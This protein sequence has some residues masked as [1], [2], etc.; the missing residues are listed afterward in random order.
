MNSDSQLVIRGVT[1]FEEGATID[2]AIVI[3]NSDL[4]LYAGPEIQLPVSTSRFTIIDGD[5][6]IVSP[7][8]IDLQINGAYGFDF[9]SQTDSIPSV[10]SRLPETG[11]TSFLPTLITSPIEDY[12][13]KLRA[14][15][16]AQQELVGARVLGA[17][18]E[19]PFLNKI[20][21]GAHNPILF[22]EPTTALL[23]KIFPLEVVRIV[24]LA[25][26]LFHSLEAIRWLVARGIIVSMGH[27]AANEVETLAAIGAGVTYGTHLFNAMPAMHHRTPG[28]VGVF[29]TSNLARFGL[30]VDGLH[31]HPR[32]VQMAWK[33]RGHKGITLITDAMEGMGMPHGEYKVGNRKVT[34]SE[35]GAWLKDGTSLAGSILSMDEAV[36]NMI[37]FSGCTPAQAIRMASTTPAEVLRI[38]DKFG[39][40]KSGYIA[41]ITIFDR[42]LLVQATIVQGTLVFSTPSAQERF[43]K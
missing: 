7:G 22:Y 25:P 23:E 11:V 41:D 31:I 19:G 9:T 40:L 24:T 16:D 20:K 29:L 5:G 15:L 17:H 28:L 4:I 2:N 18:V 12:S 42:S 14:V 27:S 32:M 26:E 43:M 33:C 35:K 34:V 3:I 30:I 39:H 8:L 13:G 38:N 36:R 6:W 37:Q 1:L 10:A 21:K